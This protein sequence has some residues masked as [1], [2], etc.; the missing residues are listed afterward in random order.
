M[1]DANAISSAKTFLSLTK[2]DLKH[3]TKE[4]WNNIKA[5]PFEEARKVL[6]ACQGKI[7][8][9][10]Y[11]LFETGY[12]PSGLP[13]IGTFGE[14]LRTTMIRHAFTLI[15]DIPT[16]LFAFSDDMD[17]LRKVPGNVPQQEML[18]QH[19]G[20][21][22]S[23]IPDPFE[24]HESFADH[25]NK[26]L[27]QFLDQFNFDYEFKSATECYK[28][29]LFNDSLLAVLKHYDKV[30]NVV[31]PTL[32]EDRRKTYSPFLPVC[33][34]TGH[35]LQVPIIE[36]NVEK[37]TVTY[38]DDNGDKIEVPV[39]DGHCK[40]QWKADW[41]M[42]WHALDVDYEMC[43]KDLTESVRLS[44]KITKILGKK[45]PQ[46]LI[47]ELFLDQNGEKIS[48]SKGNGLSMEEWLTYAP[49]ESLAYFMYQKPRTAKKL[50]FDIIPKATDDYLSELQK[51]KDQTP[52][53]QLENPVWH[54]HQ[55]VIPNN[56]SVVS[57]A[58]ILNLVSV[59][60]TEDPT[61]IWEFIE[62]YKAGSTPK[63]YPYMDLLIKYA[64]VYYKDFVKPHKNYRKPTEQEIQALNALVVALKEE[65]TSES[66]AIQNIIYRVGKE[67]GYEKT[68]DWFK[69]LYQVLLGQNH[70]PRMG[71]FVALYGK[72]ET[73]ELINKVLA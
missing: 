8:E 21:P 43:G 50:Y 68:G 71:S 28:Q 22:L 45:P 14:V 73:I 65:D 49:A 17:G 3:L 40:L 23:N 25:N 48:K 34:K 1:S 72:Q 56:I 70:G 16:R 24:C 13:H 46:G 7:P 32:G 60:N 57:F 64:L 4:D 31:L 42:R 20:K 52:E 54:I 30:I 63:D 38:K 29:G 6:E 41:A 10:G 2:E 61:M 58:M 33:P 11:V 39:T 66:D 12:G 15:S 55:G 27:C 44:S 53:E 26:L 37:G 47:Y 67:N 69:A 9:K 5:W 19:L 51:L 18:Q 36:T 35:V 62:R 59:C